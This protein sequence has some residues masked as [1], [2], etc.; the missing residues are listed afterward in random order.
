MPCFEE[1]GVKFNNIS[2]LRVEAYN[3]NPSREGLKVSIFS[4]YS[5][6]LVHHIES[7]F[8]GVEIEGLKAGA[9][10]SFEVGYTSSTGSLNSWHKVFSKYTRSI[11]RLKAVLKAVHMNFTFFIGAP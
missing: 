4:G 8:V 6:E 2:G 3:V 11:D 5:T 9:A 7:I 1:V 10:S